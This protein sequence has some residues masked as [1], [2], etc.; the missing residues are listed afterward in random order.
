M[1]FLDLPDIQG[2]LQRPYG[3][4]GFPHA[5]HFFFHVTDAVAGRHFVQALRPRVTTAEPWDKAQDASGKLIV[6][7]P[8]ITLNLG[9]SH[10]GLTALDL[11]TRTLRLFPD[12]FIDGMR[13]RADILG[14]VGTSD[15]GGWDP[16]WR[17]GAP[18]A[19]VWVMLNVAANRDGTPLAI[20]GEWTDWLVGLAGDHVALLA[21]HG[22]DGAARWQDSAALTAPLADGSGVTPVPREHFGFTDGIGDPVFRGQFDNPAAEKV[23]VVG[24]GKLD[25]GTDWSALEAG[26]FILGQVDEQQELPVASMPAEFVRN[27]TFMAWRKLGQ[28]IEAFDAEVDR[29]AA[30]WTRVN[31]AGSDEEARETVRAKLV[32]RW[33]TG[34][35]LSAAPSWADHAAMMAEHD[36]CIVI[37]LRKPRDSVEATRLEKYNLMLTGFRY[38]DDMAGAK[39]PLGAHIRRANPR[40]MLDPE[41]GPTTGSSTL[42][43]RRRILRRGLPFVDPDGSKGIVFM[44]HCASLFR[45]FEFVQQQ[46]MNYGLDFEAGNDG[47]PLIGAR[48]QPTKHVIPAGPAGA[49][50]MIA[51]DLPAFVTTRGGD[52]FFLPGIDA[53][54]MIAMGTVD[55]T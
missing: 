51:A 4:F 9:F 24:E 27:G 19:H 12:E 7:K 40:D 45:Q 3:R 23:A 55:P 1:T 35:P 31:G 8:A 50:A 16:A 37:A 32:G 10:A 2:N 21:G 52:Y 34:I 18:A 17:D 22:A 38:G 29:L 14:D 44:A 47:C 6:A 20:L 11:P 48:A 36:A 53:L 28:D 33:S 15:P 41:V 54:R 25:R 30:L 49:N 42:V 5:R 26:E 46:W 13:C 43:N 39:C